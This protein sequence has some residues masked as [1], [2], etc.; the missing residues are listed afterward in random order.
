M[1]LEKTITKEEADAGGGFKPWPDGTYDFEIK[2]AA[3]DVSKAGNSQIK[4]TLWVYDDEGH[5]RMI[6]DYLGASEAGQFKV[7][8]FCESIG[9]IRQYEEGNLEPDEMEGKTG[10]VRLGY[11]KA[12]GDYPEGN[13]VR[14]YVS[15]G[16]E[17]PRAAR[18]ASASRA[19]APATSRPASAPRASQSTGAMIDDD[20]PFA[21]EWR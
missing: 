2:E 7:R 14:D 3:D 4:L 15:G 6:F 16:D 17:A 8:H 20:I 9:M 21:P 5:R 13:Q 12:Q 18:P 10:R 1:R 19:A 11:K